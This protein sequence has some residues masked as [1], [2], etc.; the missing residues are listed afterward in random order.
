MLYSHLDLGLKMCLA[1][2][3]AKHKE[4]HT[5]GQGIF[6]VSFPFVGKD[7]GLLVCEL[8]LDVTNTHIRFGSDRYM[9]SVL[10]GCW[11]TI[12]PGPEWEGSLWGGSVWG[13]GIQ[14]H[15]VELVLCWVCCGHCHSVFAKG[16]S[17]RTFF[18]RGI[19]RAAHGGEHQ[20][21]C[22]RRSYCGNLA[23]TKVDTPKLVQHLLMSHLVIACD[24]KKRPSLKR[25]PSESSE[26]FNNPQDILP[27]PYIMQ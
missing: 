14:L 26:C 5:R 25:L 6:T 15:A 20:R 16:G 22:E 19:S 8:N 17:G 21:A 3:G 11:T 12:L 27:L 7:I 18:G 1:L 4:L 13:R 23:K 10:S 2:I 9:G 24:C